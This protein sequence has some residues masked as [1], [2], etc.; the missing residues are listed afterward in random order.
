MTSWGGRRGLVTSPGEIPAMAEKPARSAAKFN[1]TVLV[2]ACLAFAPSVRGASVTAIEQDVVIPTYQAGAPEKSPMFYF[3]GSR[4]APKG[5]FI[6]I[7][8]TTT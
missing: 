4:R 6:P 8:R 5:E 2:L 3:G 1:Q 7:R